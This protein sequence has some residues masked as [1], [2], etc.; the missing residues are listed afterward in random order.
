MLVESWYTTRGISFVMDLWLALLV[1]GRIA[2]LE[3]FLRG[4]SFCLF[5]SQG[6]GI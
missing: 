5:S 6:V 2:V 3:L 1:S 4:G